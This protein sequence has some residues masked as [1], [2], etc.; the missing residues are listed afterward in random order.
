MNIEEN[1]YTKERVYMCATHTLSP[2]SVDLPP[3]PAYHG[4]SP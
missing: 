3:Y 1:E 4:P 2:R